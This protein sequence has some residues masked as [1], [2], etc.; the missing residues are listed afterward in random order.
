MNNVLVTG[1]TG[2]IGRYAVKALLDQGFKVTAIIRNKKPLYSHENLEQI[3]ADICHRAFCDDIIAKV[4]DITSVIH[5]AADINVPGNESTVNTNIIGTW[6]IVNLAN[7]FN[8][9]KLIYLSSIPI[10]GKP[11]MT[12]IDEKHPAHPRTLYHMSKYAGEMI[13]RDLTNDNMCKTILR[14]SSPIGCGMNSATF[15]YHVL[16][17][18]KKNM[19]IFI[20]GRGSRV[21]NYID[22][23]DVVNAIKLAVINDSNHIILIPGYESISNKALVELCI[24]VTGSNVPIQFADKIDPEE[25]EQWVISNK[26]AN[27]ELFYKARYSLSDSIRWIY[28]N[29]Q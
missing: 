24:A 4:H 25:G 27:Q 14:I 1:G 29:M 16:E 18:C 17:Q 21:Q 22:V 20:Y 26:F 11:M 10:I 23:R 19:P 3:Y 28:D 9:K 2:F 15:L 13:V 6:N 5:L 12:P 8:V 7:Q